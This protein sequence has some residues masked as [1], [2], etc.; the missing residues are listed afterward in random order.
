MSP[1]LAC[2]FCANTQLHQ[3]WWQLGS[4][5]TAAV[6]LVIE[7]LVARGD[8]E[9]LARAQRLVLN[10]LV[11]AALVVGALGAL[12]A[13]VLGGFAFVVLLFLRALAVAGFTVRQRP[14]MV[15]LR[16]G[17][18]AAALATCVFIKLPA[19]RSRDE[20]VTLLTA[21]PFRFERSSWAFTRLEAEGSDG[22]AEVEQ[23]LDA[24]KADDSK[25]LVTLEL[26]QQL[27]GPAARR[28]ALC[29]RLVA[30]EH[31]E[32]RLLRIERVCE[33]LR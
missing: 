2:S 33:G 23:R 26:H 11:G 3:Q 31:D 9:A 18:T 20:L 25:A 15:A 1:L 30:S 17:V 7:L 19:N 29:S 14:R 28:G 6:V 24:L 4:V 21:T 32:Q 22:L 12:T 10:G 27:G 13:P 8:L 16:L 5:S